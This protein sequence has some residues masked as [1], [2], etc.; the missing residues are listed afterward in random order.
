M[1]NLNEQS[2]N[3][4]KRELFPQPTG[5]SQKQHTNKAEADN[6]SAELQYSAVSMST[7]RQH[8]NEAEADKESA[9]H[10][11]SRSR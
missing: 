7:E 5:L 11:Q 8:T 1:K 3:E 10:K 9:T 6:Q 2:I 4:N